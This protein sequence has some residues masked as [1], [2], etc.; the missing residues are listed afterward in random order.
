ME[1]NLHILNGFQDSLFP[2]NI[3]EVEKYSILPEGSG[4]HS[5]H[6]HEDLQFAYCIYGN[7]TYQVNGI[8]YILNENEALFIN[9]GALHMSS[10][11]SE[12]GKYMTL[13]FP[14]ELLYFF[15]DSRMKYK[16]VWPYTRVEFLRVYKISGK[17]DNELNVLKYLNQ[18][19]QVYKT[20]SIFE[21]DISILITLIWKYMIFCLENIEYSYNPKDNEKQESVQMMLVFI[22]QHYSEDITLQDISDSSMISVSQCNRYFKS[23]LNI[24]P[25]EYL[26]QYRIKKASDLLYNSTL[27]V[28]EIS[29][30]VGF[31][32]VTHFIQVFKKNY[33]ISPKKYRMEKEK[34]G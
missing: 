13:T 33:G 12:N 34:E 8:D 28:T 4:F 25:Y 1:N 11:M 5:L 9:K 30:M 15:E 20:S 26:I 10:S 31:N 27:N 18:V 22:H 29:A 7:L 24:T 32:N 17:N 14:E 19:L 3:C 21:Y 23:M 2:V 16:Y 6:W